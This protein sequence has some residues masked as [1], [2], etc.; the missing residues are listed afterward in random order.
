MLMNQPG[1]SVGSPESVGVGMV[2]LPKADSPD[3]VRNK[4]V[5]PS[6]VDGSSFLSVS[7]CSGGLQRCGAR[8]SYASMPKRANKQNGILHYAAFNSPSAVCKLPAEN[9][10]KGAWMNRPIACKVP[11]TLPM[12][13][14]Q[15]SNAAP[16]DHGCGGHLW[17]LGQSRRATAKGGGCDSGDWRGRGVRFGT[18]SI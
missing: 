8:F 9:T 17:R 14:L 1:I 13:E 4:L 10:K 3:S 7:S 12:A 11:A 5:S 6:I 18:G 15:S 2:Y 16:S